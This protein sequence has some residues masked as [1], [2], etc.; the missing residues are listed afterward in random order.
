[1]IRV[2]FGIAIGIYLAQNYN[3]PEA[4]NYLETFMI[5]LKDFEKNL[6]GKEK[7]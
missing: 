6:E 4:K 1:M 5:Y 3:V 7:K 2:A